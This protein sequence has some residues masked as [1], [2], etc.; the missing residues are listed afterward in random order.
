M[1]LWYLLA[2]FMILG[3]NSAIVD[4]CQKCED[5]TCTVVG[6]GP[7]PTAPSTSAATTTAAITTTLAT[8]A[9]GSG[10]RR[11]RRA[12]AKDLVQCGKTG[13]FA[14]SFKIYSIVGEDVPKTNTNTGLLC[15]P[16]L[17]CLGPLKCKITLISSDCT[18]LK[19]GT[20]DL[21]IIAPDTKWKV[22]N[23]KTK[24][25]A[26]KKTAATSTTSTSTGT[27]TTNA[28]S[29]SSVLSMMDI[30]TLIVLCLITY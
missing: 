26:C 28:K 19:K 4:I 11:R 10:K 16:D 17:V 8:A 7:A 15:G 3:A 13:G 29:N 12:T 27:G 6:G 24:Y 2:C 23:G 14:K 25:E 20:S 1:A 18:E 21:C 5:Q 9:P 30:G 22:S